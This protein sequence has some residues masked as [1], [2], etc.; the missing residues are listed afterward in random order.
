MPTLPSFDVPDA[1]VAVI[2]LKDGRV[3]SLLSCLGESVYVLYYWLPSSDTLDRTLPEQDPHRSTSS[4]CVVGVA[5][6]IGGSS[7]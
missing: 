1:D 2:A 6:F 7:P 4:H 3:G 5:P